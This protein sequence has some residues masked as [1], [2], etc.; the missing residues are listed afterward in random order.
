[1]MTDMIP[2]WENTVALIKVRADLA[3]VMKQRDSARH[4]LGLAEKQALNLEAEVERLE[5]DNSEWAK[6]VDR[7][8]AHRDELWAERDEARRW[9]CRVLAC[10]RRWGTATGSGVQIA[11][12]ILESKP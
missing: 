5:A 11:A 12:F 1:M 3:R 10:G 8:R 7:F 9:A 2:G 6:V 4:M